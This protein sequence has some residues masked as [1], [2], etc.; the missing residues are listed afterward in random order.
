MVL[1]IWIW[2]N[3]LTLSSDFVAGSIVF[4]L[5]T[6]ISLALVIPSISVGVRRLRDA[7]YH[8]ALLLV[9]LI[10]LVGTL[11]L[12]V[13]LASPAPGDPPAKPR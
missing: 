1:P 4:L 6:A 12:I 9:G 2:A 11:M 13:L 8:P 5:G 7:G 10:P 3:V